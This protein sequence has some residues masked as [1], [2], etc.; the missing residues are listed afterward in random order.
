MVITVDGE[1]E[2][3]VAGGGGDVGAIAAMKSLKEK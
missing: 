2:I 1:G 3:R